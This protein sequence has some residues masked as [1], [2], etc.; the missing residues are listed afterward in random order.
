MTPATLT[1]S[2]TQHVSCQI[3]PNIE[4]NTSPPPPSPLWLVVQEGDPDGW[5]EESFNGH[6]DSKPKGPEAITLDA[7]FIGASHVYGIPERATSL[8]LKPTR[9]E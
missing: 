4:E 7:S 3:T 9:G 2:L 5:W 6:S 8:A 1:H